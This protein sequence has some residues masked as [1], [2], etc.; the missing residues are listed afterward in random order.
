MLNINLIPTCSSYKKIK[1]SIM[2]GMYSL[3]VL[4]KLLGA[5]ILIISLSACQLISPVS[6]STGNIASNQYEESITGP[7]FD[8]MNGIFSGIHAKSAIED[9]IG[10]R[11]KQ[12]IIEITRKAADTDQ[13]QIFTNPV[14]GVNGKAEVVKSKVL[15]VLEEGKENGVRECKIV[16]QTI[17]LKDRR[18]ITENMTTCKGPDG[19]S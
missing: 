3:I 9:Y 19:W 17:V 4:I 6:N 8:S 15:P 10:D 18:E 12:N 13:L 2:Y 5:N 11:D 7:I 1:E 14:S 16:R